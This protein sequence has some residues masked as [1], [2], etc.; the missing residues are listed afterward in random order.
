MRE[1]NYQKM[2]LEKTSVFIDNRCRNVVRFFDRPFIVNARMLVVDDMQDI[3]E[4]VNLFFT[5]PKIYI[6]RYHRLYNMFQR[7][8]LFFFRLRNNDARITSSLQKL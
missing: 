2:I 5:K 6:F 1:G 7:L 4:V 8:F 3:F